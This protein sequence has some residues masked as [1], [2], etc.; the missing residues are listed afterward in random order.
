MFIIN[1]N[2]TKI[3]GKKECAEILEALT[4][5]N[6]LTINLEGTSKITFTSTEI[7]NMFDVYIYQNKIEWNTV[8]FR[9]NKQ[10]TVNE[11]YKVRKSYNHL[12][13]D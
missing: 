3:R 2:L 13:K 8:A 11:L 12:W 5:N 4:E 10:D 6:I 1:N 7:E 9:M